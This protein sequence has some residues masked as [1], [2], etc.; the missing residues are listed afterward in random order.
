MEE[1]L[2]D[3]IKNKKIDGVQFRVLRNGWI[4]IV[5]SKSKDEWHM[6]TAKNENAAISFLMGVWLGRKYL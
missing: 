1:R 6:I 4:D 5:I 3:F 2:L